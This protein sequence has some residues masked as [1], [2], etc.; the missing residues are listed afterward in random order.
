MQTLLMLSW[1]L[2]T[3][4]PGTVGGGESIS[5]SVEA[6]SHA[7]SSTASQIIAVRLVEATRWLPLP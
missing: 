6:V 7:E 1:L 2:V 4:T 3:E 5:R